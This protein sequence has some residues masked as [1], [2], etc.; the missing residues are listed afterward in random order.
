M[1]LEELKSKIEFRLKLEEEL[2]DLKMKTK[3]SSTV[4][5]SSNFNSTVR[6][7]KELNKFVEPVLDLKKRYCYNELID[8][9]YNDVS[10]KVFIIYGL[11]RT[12]KTTM[13]R[14]AIGEMTEDSLSKTA[15]VQIENKDSMATIKKD[16]IKLESL[17]YKYVFIDEVTLMEDFVEGAALF[18]DIFASSGMKIV[19]CG[20]DS[21]GFM[22][23]QDSQL[24]DRCIML[25]TTFISYKEFHD[26]LGIDGIDEY[27][28]YGG[29]MSISGRNYNTHYTFESEKSTSEY[30]DTA[31]ARNI[32]HSLKCYQD[33]SHFRSLEQLYENNELTNA[34]NRVVEDIN[35]R[36]TLEVLTRPFKSSDLSISARNLRSDRE[37]P[38]DILD[39]VNIEEITQRLMKLL[40]VINKENQSVEITESHTAEIKEY[41]DLLDLTIDVDVVSIDS[42]KA[43]HRTII[44]QPG[45]RYCQVEA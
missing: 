29:T 28:K 13:I 27:I 24:Y 19:L 40:D 18:S 32:Q 31:I 26:V 35:H 42:S 34:I 44:T 9:L 37:N 8:Y 25:H 16:L 22:L 3:S 15:F 17:G 41:L 39:E 38:N 2:K 14:Q 5:Q 1:H 21:L 4:K 43:N 7:G 10:D 36:F 11:R 33:G 20:T 45:M 23:S 30:V 12:G 6:I